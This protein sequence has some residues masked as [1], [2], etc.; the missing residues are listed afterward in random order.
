MVHPLDPLCG[1]YEVG[2]ELSGVDPVVE[3][4][5]AKAID[6]LLV[7]VVVLRDVVAHVPDLGQ[8]GDE[9]L[10][11]VAHAGVDRQ[12]KRHLLNS[13]EHVRQQGCDHLLDHVRGDSD[14]E[15]HRQL[16]ERSFAHLSAGAIFPPEL[17]ARLDLV[18]NLIV[19][20]VDRVESLLQCAHPH[21]V[22]ES[23]ELACQV[24]DCR[25]DDKYL[26]QF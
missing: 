16:L 15:L 12:V 21:P 9:T 10:V 11:L 6:V 1:L 14:R 17:E 13:A 3:H 8:L 4:V 18:L 26:C 20:V 24:H 2:L 19:Q 23:A 5:R 22:D 7:L 25:G